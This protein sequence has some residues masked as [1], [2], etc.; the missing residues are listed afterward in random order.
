MYHVILRK[1]KRE[2]RKLGIRKNLSGTTE[3][4]RVSVFRSNKYIYAQLIDD[5][6]G[7]TLADV[8]KETKEIHKGKPKTA[9]ALEVG[10]LL[11]EKAKKLKVKTAVFDRNGYKFHGRVK[12]VVDGLR[13]GGLSI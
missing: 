7:V 2:R 4:P 9:A 3:K 5:T 10:K 11:A 8:S 13:E 12:N 6:K 1:T